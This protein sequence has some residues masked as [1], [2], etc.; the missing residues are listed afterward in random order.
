MDGFPLLQYIIANISYPIIINIIILES[1]IDLII[2]P[3][4]LRTLQLW[5]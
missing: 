4:S 1:I 5:L 2:G 3:I